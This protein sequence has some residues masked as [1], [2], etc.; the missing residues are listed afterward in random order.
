MGGNKIQQQTLEG[1]PD[2][3]QQRTPH[4]LQAF[5]FLTQRIEGRRTKSSTRAFDRT[6]PLLLNPMSHKDINGLGGNCS[7]PL[8]RLHMY[9]ITPPQGFTLKEARLPVGITLHVSTPAPNHTP[10]NPETVMPRERLYKWDIASPSRHLL[11]HRKR[12]FA[13]VSEAVTDHQNILHNHCNSTV[14][15]GQSIP[16]LFANIIYI[17]LLCTFFLYMNNR[18]DN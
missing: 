18:H 1:P 6:P 10:H 9:N 11:F 2:L 17:L 12:Y 15:T 5:Q 13:A 4:S 7:R 8:T 14:L 3:A 16:L